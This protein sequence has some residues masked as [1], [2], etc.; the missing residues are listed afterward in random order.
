M[1]IVCFTIEKVAIKFYKEVGK[2]FAIGCVE[3]LNFDHNIF[4]ILCYTW[5]DFLN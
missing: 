2:G 5:S 3:G 1:P 4:Y